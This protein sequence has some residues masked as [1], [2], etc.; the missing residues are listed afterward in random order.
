[1]TGD[2]G[3]NRPLIFI[4]AGEP[5]GDALGARLMAALSQ[6][7]DGK[8]RFEGIGGVQMAALG[9]VSRFPM[10]ELSVMGAAEILPRLFG[11][12]RRI[13]ETA[14]AIV[15][16]RP[17]VVVT[18]DSP[19]FCFRV[20][21]RVHDHGIPI[22]HYVAP[23]VWAW[24]AHRAREIAGFLDHLLALLP[25]EPPIFTAEGLPCTFVGHPVLESGAGSGDGAAL[26]ARLS[27]DP[28]T[29]LVCLLPGSRRSGNEAAF[30]DIRSDGGNH[31]TAE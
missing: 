5:S 4:I 16:N 10:E 25:F 1:M 9:L 27:I 18:I 6:R 3:D 15:A 20:A 24:K 23:Q 8:I 12:L 26:R 31:D 30:A 2:A 14:E 19:G 21:K 29:T 17:D 22:V 28:D 11:L 7:L 13:G